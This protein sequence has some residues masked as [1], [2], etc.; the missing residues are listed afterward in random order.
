MQYSPAE[1]SQGLCP[2]G[3]HVPARTEW[4]S[5]IDDPANGGNGLAGGFLKDVP[6]V[7][8]TG[9]VLYMN[10]V[11]AFNPGDDLTATMFWTSSSNG[12]SHAYARG[13]NAPNTST[14]LYSG[15]FANAFTVRC[16]KDF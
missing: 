7:A 13:M 6:F 12:P 10:S 5:L 1:G 9:G 16:V 8:K 4:Q 3:W 15:S 11:W 2:P 14:S